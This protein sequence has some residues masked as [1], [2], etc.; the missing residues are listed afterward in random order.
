MLSMRR[1]ATAAWLG[2]EIICG[3]SLG[4]RMPLAEARGR[5]LLL[6]RVRVPA[7]QGRCGSFRDVLLVYGKEKVYGSI[8]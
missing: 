7:G 3:G 2:W 4:G 1:R 6:L 5:W 8:P